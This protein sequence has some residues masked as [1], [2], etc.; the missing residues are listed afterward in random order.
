[1]LTE[2]LKNHKAWWGK[3]GHH[4]LVGTAI[5]CLCHHVHVYMAE[6][7][8]ML[9]CFQKGWKGG[10]ESWRLVPSAMCV[11]Q[12]CVEWTCSTTQTRGSLRAT[13]PYRY[14]PYCSSPLGVLELGGGW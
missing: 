13:V 12:Q 1:M 7:C 8:R 5:E 6:M 4:G 3:R 14:G 9:E 2:T 11:C 10:M